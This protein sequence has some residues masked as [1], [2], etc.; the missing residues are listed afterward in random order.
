MTSEKSANP[1]HD[2]IKLVKA[3]YVTSEKVGKE[4]LI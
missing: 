2:D 3:G 4:L 1:H